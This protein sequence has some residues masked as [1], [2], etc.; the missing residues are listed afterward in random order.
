METWQN[1]CR[2]HVGLNTFGNE[3]VDVNLMSLFGAA[4]VAHQPSNAG[5]L[6]ATLCHAMEGEWHIFGKKNLG[7][8]WQNFAYRSATRL[9]HV[10][11][12]I[13]VPL[14]LSHY[15]ASVII[16]HL[17]RSHTSFARSSME[18]QSS[19]MTTPLLQD[20]ALL[21]PCVSKSME[22][23]K[24][25]TWVLCMHCAFYRPVL[26]GYSSL[27]THLGHWDLSKEID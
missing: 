2:R 21:V 1:A 16:L 5:R 20:T 3:H 22:F 7:S 13:S 8:N 10:P 27:T 24:K 14:H 12:H 17:I 23:A 25:L 4:V 18:H 26:P 19:T 11:I 9:C 6:Q 15:R